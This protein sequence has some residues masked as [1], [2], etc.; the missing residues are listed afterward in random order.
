MYAGHADLLFHVEDVIR[1]TQND[2][3]AVAA[4]LA[5]AR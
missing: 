2:D 4:G 5:A 1:M 3:I